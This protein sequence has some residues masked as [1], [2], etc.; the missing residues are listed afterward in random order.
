[1]LLAPKKASSKVLLSTITPTGSET[2]ICL[3]NPSSH[4][5][6]YAA[7]IKPV[8]LVFVSSKT[9]VGLVYYDEYPHFSTAQ[10]VIPIRSWSLNKASLSCQS[11]TSYQLQTHTGEEYVAKDLETSKLC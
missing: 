7:L 3:E 8:A 10:W 11:Q 1:V 2:T 4:N 6:S 5:F 9:T